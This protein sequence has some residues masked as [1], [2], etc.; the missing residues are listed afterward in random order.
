MKQ[1]KCKQEWNEKNEVQ[2]KVECQS[3]STGK[4]ELPKP[5]RMQEKMKTQKQSPSKGGLQTT[6]CN[7]K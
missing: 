6:K 5:R 2:A 7:Q 4:S 3:Q 1:T